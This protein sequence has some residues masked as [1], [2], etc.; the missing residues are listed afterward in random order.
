MKKRN[1]I[2]FLPV[3]FL[4]CGLWL[5]AEE[6]QAEPKSQAIPARRP[7]MGQPARPR[8]RVSMTDPNTQDRYPS[9]T[10][11][12]A[13][14]EPSGRQAESPFLMQEKNHQELIGQL[15]EIKKMAEEEGASK[16][17]QAIQQLIDKRNEEFKKNAEAIQKRQL[18]MQQRIQERMNRRGRPTGPAAENVEKTMEQAAP[19]QEAKQDTSGRKGPPK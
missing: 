10:G 8:A 14:Q 3:T 4:I 18:E 17:A 11:R 6:Q 5:Q 19:K 2:W 15:T 9:R 7:R 12:L 13:M 16:T 1:L